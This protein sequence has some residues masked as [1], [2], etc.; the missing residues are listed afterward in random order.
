MTKILTFTDRIF[1]YANHPFPSEIADDPMILYHGTSSCFEKEIESEGLS[2]SKVH[3]QLDELLSIAELFEK[4]GWMGKKGSMT[5]L[6]PFSI[7]H[8]NQRHNIKPIYLGRSSNLVVNYAKHQDA[9]G[10]IAKTVRYCFEDLNEFLN[11][12][13]IRK[14]HENKM[15]KQTEQAYNEGWVFEAP[16]QTISL[17]E[18]AKSLNALDHINQRALSL[19]ENTEYGIVYAI[20]FNEENA[21]HLLNHNWMGI[22]YFKDILPDQ[23]VGKAIVPK[24]YRKEHSNNY[25][26]FKIPSEEGILKMV[27]EE[28]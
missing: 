8:D 19:I 7:S 10:E 22:K 11:N 4:L 20:R 21:K 23:I 6:K 12:E 14:E 9:G 27:L 13:E 3:F 16:K 2:I 28:N 25:H 24:E 17:E 1:K 18:L 26:D 5:T 15:K